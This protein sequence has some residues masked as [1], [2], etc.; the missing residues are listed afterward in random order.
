MGGRILKERQGSNSLTTLSISSVGRL[1]EMLGVREAELRTLAARAGAYYRTHHES[2]RRLPFQKRARPQKLRRIDK[3]VGLLKAVQKG[4]HKLLPSKL[5]DH[6]MGGVKGVGIL[7][8]VRLHL[9][10]R[11]LVT[12]DI[13]DFFPSV[14][15]YQVYSVWHDLLQC[16]PEVASLLTRLTTFERRLPQGAHTSTTLANLVLYMADSSLRNECKR[17][18][19]AYSTWVD[20][21]P[22]SGDSAR[23][24]IN[25]A[26]L[27]FRRAGFVVPHRKLKIM[28]PGERK[29]ING[30]VAGQRPGVP[31][32]LLKK[33]RSGI[34]KLRIGVVP[35][36]DQPKYVLSLKGRISYVG[37]IDPRRAGRLSEELESVIAATP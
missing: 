28:G 20:D 1:A 9:G 33:L 18:G 6:I 15:T 14:T 2:R 23:E 17:V 11:V 32:E 26:V 21:I 30:V 4:I 25:I 19:V 34:H 7:Q 31:K 24:V 16:S 5:P 8:N 35:L 27:V 13:R 29:V 3:P 10:A 22:L 36:A 12:L 37:M